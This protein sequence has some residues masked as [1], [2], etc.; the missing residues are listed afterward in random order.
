MSNPGIGVKICLVHG[1]YNA[2]AEDSPCPACEDVEEFQRRNSTCNCYFC[3]REFDDSDGIPADPYNGNDG[4][5]I[6]PACVKTRSPMKKMREVL[7]VSKQLA[8]RLE[9]MCENPMEERTKE[10]TAYDE[11][12]VFDDGTRM[13]IQVCYSDTEGESC[14]C[15]G[16]LFASDGS[17]LGCTDVS[18][19]FLG[20]YFID[21]E[22]VE[23]CVDVQVRE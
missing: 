23:Y 16:V 3:G 8:A 17:E 20:E 6:C 14:W 15:Q 2:D 13:A 9:A 18:D 10:L 19:T 21:Y 11:E 5:E 22:D 12:V 7:K 1:E 4:G